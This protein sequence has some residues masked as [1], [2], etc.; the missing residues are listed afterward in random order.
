MLN[1]P[2]PNKAEIARENIIYR[3]G[4]KVMHIANDYELEWKKPIAKAVSYTE[5]IVAE[6]IRDIEGFSRKT[7]KWATNHV[8]R[9]WPF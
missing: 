7:Q 4:D 9:W 8:E 3:V 5:H 1:P 2:A 6:G